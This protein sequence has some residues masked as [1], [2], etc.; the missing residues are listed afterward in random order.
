MWVGLITVTPLDGLLI[1]VDAMRAMA[2][3]GNV[4]ILVYL[5]RYYSPKHLDGVLDE[6]VLSGNI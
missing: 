1:V 3:C 2:H 6:G 5:Y 4:T